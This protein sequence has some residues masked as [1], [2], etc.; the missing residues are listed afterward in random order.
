MFEINKMYVEDC[1]DT[2]KRM[3][4]NNQRV[5]VILTSPPYCTD[6]DDAKM[7]TDAKFDW[8]DVHYDVFE[9]FES[10][11]AYREWTVN[12]F[13]AYDT[14][15]CENGVVLYN[16]SY[17]KATPDLVYKCVY[18]VIT[19]TNF[20]VADCIIW[21]K[22]NALPQNQNSNR[23]TRICEFVFV[24][25]RKSEADT[26]IT[27]KKRSEVDY[28]RY[29]NLFYNYIEAPNNDIL[30]K[31]LNRL[32]G[33][34]FSTKLVLALLN[35][36]AKPGFIVYDSFMGTGTTAVACKQY[37][38]N[39]IG[40][41]ISQAQVEFANKRLQGERILRGHRTQKLW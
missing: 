24:F 26:F 35:I 19:Q 18:D 31:S 21:R 23:S 1:F 39:Y 9:G 32:N 7:Y 8:Y 20:M 15:L 36:Y 4:K 25:C 33:A 38:C 5:N 6:K 37:G 34:T 29:T 11:E 27:N 2:M 13:N 17:T 10:P 22:S 40:S 3:V 30:D 16:I 41:E 12:L 28:K 14:V